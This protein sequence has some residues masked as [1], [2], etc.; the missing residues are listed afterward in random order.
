MIFFASLLPLLFRGRNRENEVAQVGGR[1]RERGFFFKKAFIYYI[2]L[3][4]FLCFCSTKVGKGFFLLHTS[5]WRI[6]PIFWSKRMK[7]GRRFTK[8]QKGRKIFPFF[9]FAEI[10]FPLSFFQQKRSQNFVAFF[11]LRAKSSDP[12]PCLIN[13][14]SLFLC[15]EK[16]VGDVSSLSLSRHRSTFSTAKSNFFKSFSFLTSWPPPL[17][18][19]PPSLLPL[20]DVHSKKRKEK[21][22]LFRRDLWFYPTLIKVPRNAT[23]FC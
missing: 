20:Q 15:S 7:C 18:L 21:S 1:E 3:L 11:H 12:A 19:S 13:P 17:P 8:A 14:L 5:F 23:K 9:A 10:P 4:S 2:F 6:H 16:C 22:P